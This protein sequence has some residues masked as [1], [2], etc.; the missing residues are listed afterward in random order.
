LY[1]QTIAEPALAEAY[2]LRPC[3]AM[4]DEPGDDTAPSE[5]EAGG[6]GSEADPTELTDE[7]A[8][9]ATADDQA[10]GSQ[11]AGTGRA[12]VVPFLHQG[13][14]DQGG[15]PVPAPLAAERLR[16]RLEEVRSRLQNTPQDG[17]GEAPPKVREEL[18]GMRASITVRADGL[19]GESLSLFWRLSAAP[20]ADALPGSWATPVLASRLQPGTDSDSAAL[21]I[22][23]PLPRSPGPF[24]LDVFV[25]READGALLGS[26]RLEPVT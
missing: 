14:V 1:C 2:V 23:I 16:A 12:T 21:G 10:A 3:L 5:A 7:G 19:A 4:D 9:S 24:V 17:P 18:I 22:W 6:P 25:V 11:D 8:G 13:L 20:G 26:Q 15:R